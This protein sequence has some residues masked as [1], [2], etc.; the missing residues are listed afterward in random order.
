MRHWLRGGFPRSFLAEDD[1]AS[2]RWRQEFVLTF[3]ERDIPQLGLSIPATMLLRFWTMTAH[4]HGQT[5]NGAELA[6]SLNLSQTTV[7]RYLDLLSDLF[8]VRQLPPWHANLKKRQVR[9]PKIY[10]RDVE[11]IV[12]V[13]PGPLRYPLADRIVAMPFTDLITGGADALRGE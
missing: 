8:M 7:R 9:S 11:R 3:L 1:V 12:V 4:Y 10:F 13:Y 2:F 6:R 5:W